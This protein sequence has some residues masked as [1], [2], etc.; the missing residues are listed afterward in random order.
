MESGERDRV[1][2][3]GQRGV[4]ERRKRG[5]SKKSGR[6]EGGQGRSG[7]GASRTHEEAAGGAAVEAQ[8]AAERQ[9]RRA[10]IVPGPQPRIAAGRAVREQPRAGQGRPQR[11]RGRQQRQHRPHPDTDSP[12]R[13]RAG[14]AE[15]S[16]AER[17][18][19]PPA[20]GRDGE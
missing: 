18:G 8:G 7:A 15:R 14:E 4:M 5:R 11:Q 1:K 12:R 16:R 19:R 2:M 6:G 20:P 10:L 3:E 17:T 13:R 9:P